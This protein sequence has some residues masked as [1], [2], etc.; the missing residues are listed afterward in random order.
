MYKGG[1]FR[2]ERELTGFEWERNGFDTFLFPAFATGL[3]QKN[4]RA[5]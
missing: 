5:K 2:A 4:G 3:Y 1:V